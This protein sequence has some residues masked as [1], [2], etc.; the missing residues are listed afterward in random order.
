MCFMSLKLSKISAC[1]ALNH[2]TFHR[3]TNN[4]QK[5]LTDSVRASH[6]SI[7]LWGIFHWR[8]EDTNRLYRRPR[9]GRWVLRRVY[10]AHTSH[11]FPLYAPS[12]WSTSFTKSITRLYKARIAA[13]YASSLVAEFY[14]ERIS[15]S[16]ARRRRAR[17]NRVF[18]SNF[19]Q[20]LMIFVKWIFRPP[21]GEGGYPQIL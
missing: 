3:Y 7:F 4:P 8:P 18:D 17:K 19:D 9:A 16:F 2:H 20:N 11:E 12:V 10:R 21:G 14:G 6:E 1:G 15:L 13:I 5:Y